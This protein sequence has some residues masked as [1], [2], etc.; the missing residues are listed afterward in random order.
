MVCLGCRIKLEDARFCR[1]ERST[2]DFEINQYFCFLVPAHLFSG[3]PV[4]LTYVL[5]LFDVFS[6]PIDIYQE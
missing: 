3:S 5:L 1:A 6:H 2:A 4:L